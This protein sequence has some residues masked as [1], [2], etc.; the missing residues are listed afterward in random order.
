MKGLHLSAIESGESHDIA[1]PDELRTNLSGVTWFPDGDRLI[2]EAYSESEGGVLWLISIFGGAPRK[3]RTHSFGAKVSPDGSSVAFLGSHGREIWVAG[4]DGGNAKRILSRETDEFESLAWSPA[5]QRLAYLKRVEKGGLNG[6]IGGSIETLSLDGG[7]LSVVVS[8]PGVQLW[9]DLVWLRDGRLVYSSSEGLLSGRDASLWQIM[10]DLR[11][12]LPS[13][14]PAKMTNWSGADAFWPSVSSDGRRLAV[15]K[16]HRWFD[17]YVVELKQ[18]GMRL[19][20]PKRLTSSDS[21]NFPSAWTRDSGTILFSSDRMGRDQIFKQRIDADTAELLVKGPD[22]QVGAAF[23][24]D[25]AWILYFSFPHREN[26]PATSGRLMR[27]PASGGFPEQVLEVPADRMIAYDCPFRPSS[28]CL[29]SRWEQDQLIFYALDPLQGQ[30]KEIIR[31]KLRQTSDL[32]WSIS[33]DG[34]HIAIGSG[35]QLRDQVRILDLR[36]GTE[37]NLQLPQGWSI[38]GLG[39]AA[40]GGALFVGVGSTEFFIARID[41][42]GKTHIFLERNNGWIGAPCLSPD[43]RHLAYYQ[44]TLENNVWLLENF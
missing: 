18:D 40:D 30:G 27:F 6:N 14:K 3:L 23:S 34:S 2:V 37:R 11:T 8:D 44:Q 10:T 26:L 28:S 19:D 24:A 32:F 35:T 1:L 17:M 15:A 33:P 12:G 25:A 41:L 7:S 5:G 39:W 20:S 38:M 29:I 13:G 43:G 21:N 31:T 36:N 4:A 16:N 22:D 42:D 9:G